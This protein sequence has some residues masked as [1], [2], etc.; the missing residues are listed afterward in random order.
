MAQYIFGVFGYGF[1]RP[2]SVPGIVVTPFYTSKNQIELVHYNDE[3]IFRLTG[4][5][6]FESDS[7]ALAEFQTKASL[8]ADILTFCEQQWV[9]TSGF[10]EVP[11]GEAVGTFALLKKER[12]IEWEQSRQRSGSTILPQDWWSATSR[13]TVTLNLLDRLQAA[14]AAADFFRKGFYRCIEVQKLTRPYIDIVHY[15][16]FSALELLARGHLQTKEK[17][18]GKVISEFLNTLGFVTKQRDW[19]GWMQYRNALFH[20]GNLEG[21]F[22]GTPVHL[23]DLPQLD[24]LL[25]DVLLKLIDCQ[26]PWINWNRWKDRMAF[27]APEAK[28]GQ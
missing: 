4:Y 8:L 6:A 1:T 22:D 23:R 2:F 14:D 13:E 20:Q 21:S 16:Q 10:V 26:D 28:G 9:I 7:K 5:G 3:K 27:T 18:S 19:E 25:P 15:L 12:A 11:S 24:A 17:N